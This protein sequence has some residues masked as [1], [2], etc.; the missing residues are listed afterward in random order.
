MKKFLYF[1]SGAGANLTEEAYVAEADMISCVVPQTATKTAIYFSKTDNTKDKIVLSHDNK[2]NTSGHRII[3]I[4]KALAEAANAGPHVNGIV[5]VVDLD[6]SIFYGNLSFITGV[7][8]Q[9]N[10]GHD[11]SNPLYE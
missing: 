7:E 3:D 2:T 10:A 11:A 1:A 8:I 4:G 9:L 5:D 6:N